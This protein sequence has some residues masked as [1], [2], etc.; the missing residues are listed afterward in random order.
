MKP[1][2]GSDQASDIFQRP[3]QA[4]LGDDQHDRHR[5]IDQQSGNQDVDQSVHAK[6]RAQSA[7]QLP[8]TAAKAPEQPE[9]QEDS[10]SESRAQQ[11]HSSS[12]PAPSDGVKANR[13]GDRRIS[14]PIRNAACAQVSNSRGERKDCAKYPDGLVENAPI[15][16]DGIQYGGAVNAVESGISNVHCYPPAIAPITMKGSLPDAIS[17]GSG[18]S[19]ES[20]ER[21]SSQAK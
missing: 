4:S 21:S 17:S 13:H 5:R 9:G 11:R 14:N 15:L 10:E 20:C 1:K 19:G 12:R 3:P 8:I 16:Q 2:K 6:K 18:A 7:D